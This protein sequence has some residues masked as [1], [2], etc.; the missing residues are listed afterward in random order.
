MSDKIKGITFDLFN[1]L[2]YPTIPQVSFF[3]QSNYLIDNGYE[4][5]PQELEAARSYVFFVDLAKF[6]IIDWNSWVRQIFHRLDYDDIDD[7]TFNGFIR[8]IKR[9]SD[10]LK[11][12]PE[13]ETLLK[14]IYENNYKLSIVTTIPEFRFVEQIK[15]IRKY[16]EIIVT[17][18]N[19][20]CAKG[21]KKM[22]QF[23]LKSKSLTPSQNCFIGDDS[24]YDIYYPKK[25]GQMTILLD[26]NKQKNQDKNADL[27]INNLN[28]IE[29]I[30]LKKELNL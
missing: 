28:Q 2:I 25:M 29:E 6:D 3:D 4:I 24:L 7:K 12:F 21:N 16:F 14:R 13:V 20:K 8:L 17:A 18:T 27:I 1:T 22:Y 19:A 11:L 15:P 10:E 30:F 26:R 23:D 9:Y 5:Y